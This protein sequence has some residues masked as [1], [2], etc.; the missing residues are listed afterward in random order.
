MDWHPNL[1]APKAVNTPRKTVKMDST[2]NFPEMSVAIQLL[3]GT[4]YT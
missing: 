4:Y 2:V 1:S 3:I